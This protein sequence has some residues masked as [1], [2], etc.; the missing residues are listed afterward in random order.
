M[1]IAGT[2]ERQG[3]VNNPRISPQVL[4]GVFLAVLVLSSVASAGQALDQRQGTIDM[5]VGGL[6]VNPG[7]DLAQVVTAG[8]TGQLVAVAFPVACNEDSVLVVQVRGV[9]SGAPDETVLASSTVSGASLPYWPYPAPVTL[10]TLMLSSAVPLMAGTPFAIVLRSAGD[11]GVFQGPEGN[12]YE[13]GDASYQDPAYPGWYPVGR[14]LP[15]ETF[16]MAGELSVAID[17]KPDSDVNS[18][19]IGSAGVV[20]V[21][22]LSSETFDAT[23]VDPASVSLAD[24]GVKVAGKASHFLCSAEDVNRD[25][26]LDLMCHV[27]AAELCVEPGDT[28]AVLE[29]VTSTGRRVRGQDVLRIVR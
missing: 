7:Q 22:I 20:P 12:V 21:A 17:I 26:R 6:A 5:S 4:V 11:C 9:A 19:K 29:A 28:I 23:T 1:G 14:D 3:L 25:G 2:A 18:V 15:F 13:G 27:L 16:M 10:R 24:A 8:R